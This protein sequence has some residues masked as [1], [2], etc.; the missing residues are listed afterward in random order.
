M[1]VALT[2]LLTLSSSVVV[3]T[4]GV[5]VAERVLGGGSAAGTGAG[6]DDDSRAGLSPVASREEA[7][8]RAG[9]ESTL[10]ARATALL[11][12]D[13]AGWLAAISPTARAYRQSQSLVF[14]RLRYLHV[15][16][17]RYTVRGEVG[18]LSQA[19]QRDLGGQAWLMDV[20]LSYRLVGDTRDTQ[21][22]QQLSVV[23]RGTRWLLV[24]DTDGTTQRDLWDLGPVYIEDGERSLIV[25]TARHLQRLRRYARETDA[26]A[27][28]VDA[29]WGR[30]WPRTV[31]VQVPEDQRQMAKLL[32]RANSTGLDQVAAVTIGELDRQAGATQA[33]PTAD[34]IILNPSAFDE[35]G[36]LGRRIVLTHEVTH[37][38]TRAS[39][40]L[41]T[42]L[43]LEEGFADYVAY[44]GTGLTYREIAKDLLVQVRAGKG[45]QTLPGQEDF[46]PAEGDVAPAYVASWLA[47]E[48]IGSQGGPPTVVRFYQ[49]AAGID[50]SRPVTTD[51]EALSSA[52]RR[53]LQLDQQAFENQWLAEIRRLSRKAA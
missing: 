26:A 40:V 17:W 28:R 52:F 19:R 16:S 24:G 25:G 31:V 49:I 4:F 10:A 14:S 46:D 9:L 30:S 35:M 50:R 8:R 15:T 3:V 39:S 44:R 36:S 34:R 41:S 29:V 11:T 12:R 27:R 13:R 21:R 20:R 47:V 33:S 48:L 43:W 51:Q 5:R 1:A 6:G 18:E 38:A 45:P 37:V 7:E 23:R 32:G 2:V 22:S 53:V 42:P